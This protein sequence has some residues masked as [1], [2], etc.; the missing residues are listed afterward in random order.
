MPELGG[1][2]ATAAIR[3]RERVAGGHVRIVAM[4]A[5]AMTGDRERCIAAGMDGYLS[6]PINPGVLFAV[7][8]DDAPI[9]SGGLPAASAFD[10]GAALDRLNGDEALLSGVIERF[11][12]ECPLRL[13]AIKTA[14][15]RRDAEG[16]R[17]EAHSLKGAA[18][19]LSA[20]GLFEAAQVVERIGTENR[21]DA[22]E[23]AWRRLSAEAT[24]VLDLLRRH[25]TSRHGDAQPH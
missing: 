3:A 22:A 16:L 21:L 20:V 13:A 14:V 1:F 4:T 12:E 2:E 17:V 15:D 23:A 19:N 10:R 6:K 9:R 7:V 5:H 18:G 24:Q 11:L 8:E 25:E